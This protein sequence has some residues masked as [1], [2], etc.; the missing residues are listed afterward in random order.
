MFDTY[1]TSLW[2]SV[3]GANGHSAVDVICD[4][5]FNG[6]RRCQGGLLVLDGR[7]GRE[8]WRHFMGSEIFALN[9]NEDLNNDGHKECLASGRHGVSNNYCRIFIT[10]ALS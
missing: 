1:G 10:A 3:T 6:S 4:V 8:L 7:D 9:C 5:Y 2:S